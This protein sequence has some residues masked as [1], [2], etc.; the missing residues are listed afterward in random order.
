MKGAIEKC[1]LAGLIR[2]EEPHSAFVLH[3]VEGGVTEA[4]L[5]DILTATRPSYFRQGIRLPFDPAPGSAP[6]ECVGLTSRAEALMPDDDDPNIAAD[7]LPLHDH[8]LLVPFVR[9]SVGFAHRRGVH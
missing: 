1:P 5:T 7:E 4:R 9:A 8:R 3:E 2:F 6:V